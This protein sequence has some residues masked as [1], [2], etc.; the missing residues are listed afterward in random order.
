M[1]LLLDTHLLLAAA[2]SNP[3]GGVRLSVEAAALI[4]DPA[5][6]P[7]FSVASIW[8][9]AIKHGFGRAEFRADPHLLRRGLLDNGYEEPPITGVHALAA[10]DP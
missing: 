4:Y 6:A 1:R 2:G 7:L 3:A 10:A 9:V 5:H 8:E